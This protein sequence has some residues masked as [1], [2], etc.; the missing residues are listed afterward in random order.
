MPESSR[1]RHRL[2]A[3]IE[4]AG[5]WVLGHGPRV[6]PFI[7]VAAA[8]LASWSALRQV[9]PRDVS[10]ALHALDIQW[11]A[12]A[13]LVTLLN[14]AAMGAYDV[15]A[16][17]HTRSSARERWKYGAVCFAWSNFLSLGP[18]AGPAIRFWLYRPAVQEL[19]DLHGG[20]IAVATAFGSGL[21]GWI[22]AAMIA[23]DTAGLPSIAAIA[24]GITLSL[25]AVIHVTLRARDGKAPGDWRPAI[26]LAAVGWLD[27][28]LAGTVFAF[29]LRAAGAHMASAAIAQ[30]FFVGQGIGLLSL[31]PG[32][33]GS[34]DAYW[35]HALP[36]AP[37]SAAALLVGY[38]SLYYVLPW[39]FASLL[40]LS[41][42]NSRAPRRVEVARRIVAGLVGGGGVLIMASAA[43]PALYARL[44]LI[45]RVVPLPLVE[46]GH[47]AAAMAGL[48]LLVLARGLARG[49][50]AA[51]RLT[52]SL[53]VVAA[54]GALLKG[55]DWEEAAILSGLALATWSQAALFPRPSWG[56][57]LERPDV[58]VATIA[59]VLFVALGIVSHR[60][61]PAAFDRWTTI[62]YHRETARFLRTAGSMALAVSAAGIYLLLRP[63]IRFTRPSDDEMQRVLDLHAQW[64]GGTNPMM[65]GAG[66]KSIFLD[67]DRGF[68]LYRTVGPYIVVFSD[69]IV[70]SQA[71]R[72]GFLDAFFALAGELDRRPVFYQISLDWIPV[73]HDRGY[74]FFK[75]GE[76]AQVDLSRITLSGHEGKMYRQIL[77]RAERDGV[78]FRVL[79]PEETVLRLDELE[80]ISNEWLTTKGLSERQFS[81][82]FFDRNYLARYPC[83]VVEET[84]APHRI[85]AFANLLEGPQHAEA[86]VDLMRHRSDGPKVMD[87]LFVSLFLRAQERGYARFNLGM[88]PLASVGEHRGA[89]ARERLAR[90]LF[91]RG[92]QWYNFQGLRAY[93]D[94]FGPAWV[95]RYMAYQD[96]WEWP[97][98]IAYVSALIAGGWGTILAPPR[99][100]RLIPGRPV[101]QEP[102][103]A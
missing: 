90:V 96:A 68:C 70:R 78:R 73:L 44:T 42:A 29:A 100:G 93:K 77:R 34:S 67:S 22:A 2:I 9:H 18:L 26:A 99:E 43:S 7:A 66:D 95:P 102:L 88:A 10:A 76:E 59:L 75:L 89:H 21:A 79:S 5:L 39:I 45:E 4:N 57:W 46:A 72:A 50:R 91:Q 49:Y 86:S 31:V 40:L 56:D 19:S 24:F 8:L 16:F 52:L 1:A 62:G 23:G 28:L 97:V 54:A 6:W 69:P 53:L 35:L 84:T 30:I 11:M 37:G 32:G 38:R 85:V 74:D 101:S 64:G 14:I 83:A 98:A 103:E 15:V 41:W 94:K 51:F 20:V 47:F 82:G 58:L 3:S 60:I 87:F 80:A 55:L 13:G 63:P 81:V 71:D 12:A 33:F 92:E 17:R 36:L 25:V 61:T 27:W 48:L 65:V